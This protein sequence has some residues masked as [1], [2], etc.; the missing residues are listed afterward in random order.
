MIKIG[1]YS[2]ISSEYEEVWHIMRSVKQLPKNSYNII[3][4][5]V[6]ILSPSPDLFHM[7]LDL[8]KVGAWD[9]LSFRNDYLPRFLKEM[10]NREVFMTLRELYYLSKTKNI[11]LLCA[12][13]NESMCHRSIIAGILQGRFPDIEIHSEDLCNYMGYYF[14]LCR[15]N[16]VTNKFYLLVTG[17]P[18]YNNY[19]ELSCFLDFMLQNKLKAGLE[20]TIVC[21]DN[22]DINKLIKFYANS[23]AYELKMFSYKY[24]K[25]TGNSNWYQKIKEMHEFIATPSDMSRGCVCFWDG[26]SQE[27]AQNFKIAITYDTPLKIYDYNKKAWIKNPYK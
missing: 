2:D 14:D 25:Y 13:K 1:T 15:Q 26:Q 3:H 16:S 19:E 18:N 10:N 21:G 20:I 9:E 11:L 4:K 12:C 7:Y 22:G 17:N 24:T 5:H 27:V 8:K 6:P 23:R